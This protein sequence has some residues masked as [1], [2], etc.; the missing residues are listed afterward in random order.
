MDVRTRISAALAL[1]LAATP[2]LGAGFDS[3]NITWMMTATV[4]VIFMSLPGL[5]L[6]YGGLT[7]SRNMLSVLMQVFT[8][9]CVI[10]VLWVVY[11]YSVAFSGGNA[12]FGGLDKMFLEGVIYNADGGFA[13]TATFSKGVY[14]PELL[15]A[16]FQLTFAAITCA[17]ITGA[18]AERMKFA[19]VL[20]FTVI[21][22][23]FSYLPMAHMVWW[24]AGPDAYTSPAVIAGTNAT[25]GLLWQWGALDFAGGTVV[26]I[27]S[28]VAALIAALFVGRRAGYGR[29]PMPP[30]NLALTL[31]GAC[32]LWVG[33]FG[34]N[35][36]SNLEANGYAVLALANTMI[37]TAVAA[38]AWILAETLLKGRAS[39]LGAVTGAIAGLVAITPACGFVG[40]PGALV[41]GAAGGFICFAA[42]DYLK[43]W[44]GYDDALDVFGVHGI[45]GMVGA[46]LTGVFVNPALG[47]AGYVVDGWVG[48]Q[49]GY[50]VAQIWVQV[51]A[52]CVAFV[53]SAVVAA[54]ALTIVKFT[55]GL[56]VSEEQE[57]VG[58]DLA[59]HG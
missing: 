5:A 47:G 11:G 55:V 49:F 51:E 32:M 39:L 41:I 3:G 29:V 58:L 26:H 15:F 22:F 34:F 13:A 20:L 56:R 46:I 4:L 54:I 28:G 53:W 10:T 44:L 50:D 40:V 17:L 35:A 12:F 24:W 31:T 21:W 38:L 1:L 6:F 52:V 43:K 33:W 7:R 48:P 25:A 9:F 37:A 16:M 2:A 57:S 59:E 8:I 36:G 18:Y 45:G 27:N 19:A 30:N 23:T 14:I 42:V